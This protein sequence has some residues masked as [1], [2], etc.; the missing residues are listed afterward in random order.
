MM[1]YDESWPMMEDD[2]ELQ[3]VLYSEESGSG[4][5]FWIFPLHFLISKQFGKNV[6]EILLLF[7]KNGHNSIHFS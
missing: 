5:S 2:T 4:K 3:K 7:F 1:T 6:K